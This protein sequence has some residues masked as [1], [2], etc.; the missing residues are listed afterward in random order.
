MAEN[1]QYITRV[2]QNGKILIS[3]DVIATIAI[4]SLSDIEGFAGLNT[5]PGADIAEIIK[6]NWGKGMKITI[7]GDNQVNV[8]CNALVYYGCNVIDTAK[9]IQKSITSEIESVAGVTVTGVNV[10]VC[11][12]VRR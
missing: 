7:S 4:Q 11:G 12:I 10:N 3:E 9:E 2:Q 5:R 6:K 8:E 1:K